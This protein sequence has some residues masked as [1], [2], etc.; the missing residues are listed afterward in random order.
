MMVEKFELCV[1]KVTE[2]SQLVRRNT[3]TLNTYVTNHVC[4]KCNHGW[5]SALEG[6][7]LKTLGL[8]VEP[9]WPQL[10]N[11][12]FE[13]IAKEQHLLGRWLLKTAVTAEQNS[14]VRQQIIPVWMRPLAKTG[15]FTNDIWVDL[16]FSKERTVAL[17]LAKGFPIIN[18]NQFFP[19][20]FHKDGFSF[21]LQLNHLLL[22]IIHAPQA[23]PLRTVTTKG[24]PVLT[25][26]H[27]AY[28]EF[29]NFKAFEQSLILRTWHGKR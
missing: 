16:G 13:Q 8:L 15:K 2:G 7:F 23:A 21:T 28:L 14:L 1:G 22:R 17:V 12:V 24:Q 4:E 29:E 25:S 19:M 10:A 6:W 5:M 3:Q 18:G 26:P 11:T 9:T 27:R 20:Q